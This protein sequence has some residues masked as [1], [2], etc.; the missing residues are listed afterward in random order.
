VP[1]LYLVRHGR[2]AA[3]SAEAADAGLDPIGVK[4][5]EAVAERLA[6]LGPL[7][8]IVS[9]LRR[10][11]ETAAPLERRWGAARVE[12][13]VGE[14]AW[15]G[16]PL[17]ARREWLRAIMASRWGEVDPGLRAW[18][19]SVIATLLALPGSSV[20]FSHFVAINAA[21]SAATGD[22]RV[23]SFSPDHCSVTVLDVERGRFSLVERGAEAATR[24]M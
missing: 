21:V 11:R 22:D 7:P 15:L 14:V 18:R 23:I 19:D 8:I 24:V 4:Q 12:P 13:G 20:A 1:R 5:A 2:P 3:G 10:T 17:A 6:P 16:T 9:P